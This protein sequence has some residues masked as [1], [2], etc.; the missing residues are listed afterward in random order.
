MQKDGSVGQ[1]ASRAEGRGGEEGEGRKGEASIRMTATS[2]L[3]GKNGGMG[4]GG[5]AMAGKQRRRV[6]RVKKQNHAHPS[7]DAAARG[8]GE[9][10]SALCDAAAHD[11]G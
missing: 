5:D 7:V 11:A 2:F 6:R 10:P 4:K 8:D 1:D 9:F 3:A